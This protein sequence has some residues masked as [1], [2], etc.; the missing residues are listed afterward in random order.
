[1]NLKSLKSRFEKLE[2]LKFN[3][4]VPQL[5][6]QH[7]QQQRASDE[8]PSLRK[9]WDAVAAEGVVAPSFDAA[10]KRVER[11]HREGVP[12]GWTGDFLLIAKPKRCDQ[13]GAVLLCNGSEETCSARCFNLPERRA[14]R[15]MPSPPEAGSIV[16]EDVHW[17][18]DD[19]H[20]RSMLQQDGFVRLDRHQSGPPGAFGTYDAASAV[21][22]VLRWDKIM[23]TLADLERV[24]A[25]GRPDPL[26]GSEFAQTGTFSRRFSRT[27]SAA[28]WAV[29]NGQRR[30]PRR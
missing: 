18:R 20:T 16:F 3:A 10:R 1:M 15:S 21:S 29:G 17:R 28:V 2:A 24:W 8:R 14:Y 30:A 11:V 27:W 26:Q 7:L 13:C 23:T 12:Q 6:E 22:Q 9:A 19:H 4:N 5:V 25:P